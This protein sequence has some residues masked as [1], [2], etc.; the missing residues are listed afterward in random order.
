MI[1][2]LSIGYIATGF[3]TVLILYIL[4]NPGYLKPCPPSVAL[5]KCRTFF[6]FTL[7]LVSEPEFWYNVLI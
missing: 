3:V 2:F 1:F 5:Y 7:E 6:D 4:S